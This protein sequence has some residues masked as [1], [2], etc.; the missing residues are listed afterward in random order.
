MPGFGGVTTPAGGLNHNHH[1]TG[2][3]PAGNHPSRRRISP[4]FRRSRLPLSRFYWASS[5]HRANAATRC[6]SLPLVSPVVAS[7]HRPR[8]LQARLVVD[9]VGK[10]E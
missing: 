10:G 8:V 6:P 3:P 5:I 1:T 7:G 4:V 9:E 2:E